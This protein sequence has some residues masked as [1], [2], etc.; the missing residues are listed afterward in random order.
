MP[1]SFSSNSARYTAGNNAGTLRVA[2]R[3]TIRQS[4]SSTA[5]STT[6]SNASVVQ[7]LLVSG[8]TAIKITFG[9][10]ASGAVRFAVTPPVPAAFGTTSVHASSSMPVTAPLT[11][12]VSGP[13]MT[14]LVT[15]AS[16]SAAGNG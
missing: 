15:G 7:G 11:S 3:S 5:S 2:S 1:R 6:D 12:F 14:A 9:A 4:A 8:G 16:P 10:R 13:T